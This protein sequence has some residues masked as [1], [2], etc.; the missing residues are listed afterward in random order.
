MRLYEVGNDPL[1]GLATTFNHNIWDNVRDLDDSVVALLLYTNMVF[2]NNDAVN[3]AVAV[4]GATGSDVF[5]RLELKLGE[6]T[7]QEYDDRL[8]NLSAWFFAGWPLMSNP[9]LP[10]P[11]AV[12]G[13]T[14]TVEAYWLFP[15]GVRDSLRA[16]DFCVTPSMLK[17]L[18]VRLT[19]APLASLYSG[20]SPVVMAGRVESSIVGIPAGSGVRLG[21]VPVIKESDHN[22]VAGQKEYALGSG[23]LQG[24]ILEAGNKTFGRVSLKQASKTWGS[25]DEIE[26]F[27]LMARQLRASPAEAIAV[28]TTIDGAF[29]YE[30]LNYWLLPCSQYDRKFGKIPASNWGLSMNLTALGG[31]TGISVTPGF[32][33]FPADNV[34]R[35][36]QM[37]QTLARRKGVSA[38]ADLVAIPQ[39]PDLSAVPTGPS[40]SSSPIPVKIVSREKALR[41]MRR[42]AERPR[43]VSGAD[44]S[45]GM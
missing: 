45:G 10:T 43:I 36:E 14:Q 32:A 38:S 13:G 6:E 30:G 21:A 17:D 37:V 28:T 18:S 23:R 29:A 42:M 12:G 26:R 24:V 19:I 16:L 11:I 40:G 35:T 33:Q 3:P 27:Q 20:A 4:A 44:A 31:D 34:I 7:V 39:A 22:V 41:I 1:T 5:A 8:V 15:L 9:A 2:T 25:E